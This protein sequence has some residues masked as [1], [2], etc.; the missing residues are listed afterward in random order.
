MPEIVKEAQKY[1]MDLKLNIFNQI[2]KFQKSKIT[3]IVK[4]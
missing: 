1:V 3:K 2:R 4:C